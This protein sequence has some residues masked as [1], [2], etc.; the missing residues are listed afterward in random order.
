MTSDTADIN[1]DGPVEPGRS[2]SRFI[3]SHRMA[4]YRDGRA[5]RSAKGNFSERL[6]R[7]LGGAMDIVSDNGVERDDVRRVL[8][9]DADEAEL[10]AKTRELSPDTIVERE[11]LRW[12]ASLR[13]APWG[14]PTPISST[15][16]VQSVGNPPVNTSPFTLTV[17]SDGVPLV[18]A[19]V[20]LGLAALTPGAQPSSICVATDAQGSASFQFDETQYVPVT[21]QISPHGSAWSGML[22]RPLS[23]G[24][25]DLG[26]LPASGPLGWW[27]HL[28]GI[29]DFDLQAGA[30]IRVGVIDS[31]LGP[32][33]YLDHIVTAG[34]F[35]DGGFQPGALATADV[36][37]HGTHVSGLIGARPP[38]DTGGYAGLA[39][40]A[41]IFT[42]RVFAPG[43]GANQ[44]DIAAAIDAMVNGHEVDLINL[45]LGGAASAIEYDAVLAAYGRGALCICAAG[46][47]FGKP[48][49]A[50]ASY[51]LS[52]AVSAVTMPGTFP[53]SNLANLTRPAQ[54]DHYG[55]GG[56][57]LPTYSNVGR[58]MAVTAGGSAVISAVPATT[59][60]PAPY[61]DMSG[62]SMATPVTT[63]ALAARL[64]QDAVYNT[65]QRTS[66]RAKYARSILE[67]SALNIGLAQQYQGHGLSRSR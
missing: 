34:A 28:A 36:L 41:D 59:D 23:G 40:G 9:I 64:S 51:P 44:G 52:V 42:A 58:Q 46:N 63:G 11:A 67:Q 45:S 8:V 30:G 3:I 26:S 25:M 4:P 55:T 7:T 29:S 47:D 18:G 5:R 21:A 48:V 2:S 32:H 15:S 19:Q 22:V 27:H 31:G 38:A 12:P 65:L 43:R 10:L 39:P 6:T 37:W 56:L 66:A 20:E 14:T 16:Q 57:F 62:T 53:V 1:D 13:M 49:L 17:T 60:D 50:P 33:A 35:I 54:P 61:A 24:T